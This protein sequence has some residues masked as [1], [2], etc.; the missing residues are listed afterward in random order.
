L[1][2]TN[3]EENIMGAFT[4]SQNL[5]RRNVNSGTNRGGHLFILSLLFSVTL[6]KISV[7]SHLT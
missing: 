6:P 3:L 2:R 1:S 7:S 4:V 5:K